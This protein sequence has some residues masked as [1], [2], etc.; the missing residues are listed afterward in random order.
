MLKSFKTALNSLR[1]DLIERGKGKGRGTSERHLSEDGDHRNQDSSPFNGGMC[2]YK[3]FT[4]TTRYL[5]YGVG[6]TN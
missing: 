1:G 5:E 4:G 2:P 6:C 3:S